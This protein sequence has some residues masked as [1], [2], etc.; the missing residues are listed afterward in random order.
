MELNVDNIVTRLKDKP[1][2]L[3]YVETEIRISDSKL[4]TI[5]TS[6]TGKET[7]SRCYVSRI[8]SDI[9]FHDPDEDFAIQ[10]TKSSKIGLEVVQKQHAS[11]KFQ[12]VISL[13]NSFYM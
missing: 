9:I 13:A 4:L 3:Q 10:L 1:N 2:G 5:V 7:I 6:E 11:L 12:D 8:L